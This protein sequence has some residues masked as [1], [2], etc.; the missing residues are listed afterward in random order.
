MFDPPA[1]DLIKDSA[2]DQPLN[3]MML[4]KQF[5]GHFG[6]FRIFFEPYGDNHTYRIDFHQYR[7]RNGAQYQLPVIRCLNGTPTIDPPSPQLLAIHKAI[8]RILYLS[9]AGEYIERILRDFED[10]QF[11]PATV[12]SG[13]CCL[14]QIVS[15][16]LLD[17][18]LAT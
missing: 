14:G 9:G 5:H 17:T 15:M 4:T 3:A 10:L 13:T 11:H 12:E 7:Y 1:I 8:G 18:W 6:S 16:R 2:I